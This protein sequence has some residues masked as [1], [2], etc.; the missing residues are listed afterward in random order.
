M[1]NGEA[2]KILIID[3][4]E[5]DYFIMVDFI[6]EIEGTDFKIDW[7]NNSSDAL[8]QIKLGLH[9]VYFIDY[10]LGAQ[11]GLDLVKEAVHL[12]CES[13]IILLTGNG[14]K[15]LD[16]ESMKTG[17]T[18]YLVKSELSAEKL[19]R[20]VRY[21]LDRT[22]SLKIIK[23]SESKYRN[24][25]SGSKDALF[26]A[27]NN[28]LFK[29]VNTAACKLFKKDEKQLLEMDL[30]KFIEENLLKENIK[31]GLLQ[32]KNVND[33]EITIIN[34]DK[35]KKNCLLSLLMENVTS[36]KYIIHGIVHDITNIK[37]AEKANLHA[38]KL[39]ANERLVRVLAHEIR[40]PLNNIKLSADH[41]E[42]ITGNN[43]QQKAM[44]GIIQRNSLR[45]NLLITELLDSTKTLELDF[46][47][48]SLQEIIEAGLSI[49]MDRII[50]RNIKLHTKYP[51][52][53]LYIMADK[54]KLQI[55]F[56][57]I[58]INAVEAMDAGQGELQVMLTVIS[59]TYSVTIKDN[60]KGIPEEQ[61]SKLFEP[62]FTMKKN[63]MGLGLS[64][65]YGI[66]KS[67]N[68]VVS[69]ESKENFG[70]TFTIEFNNNKTS[71]LS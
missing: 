67:H 62:F 42:T 52:N 57:N 1:L 31:T 17:A 12:Q 7:C 15:A 29:E 35:E 36:G 46:E 19:E 37:K 56:S 51:D 47:Q 2:V 61:M 25:F 10:R 60:G 21:S 28:L 33:L 32:H 16:V 50:L 8:A 14:N 27:D 40:N 55:G 39:A 22:A 18:D 69:V 59:N 71:P 4:D 41:L 3:D 5:D 70:T 53:P 43:E 26:I 65:A 58:F 63:G 49:A 54:N 6:R 68:S 20:C 66:F 9:D 38:E 64:A 23:E 34:E 11:N 45:I 48:Y 44:I 30:Y 24:L 13:P